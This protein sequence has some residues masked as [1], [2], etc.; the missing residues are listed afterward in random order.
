[1]ALPYSKS[2]E[3][4]QKDQENRQAGLATLKEKEA[5]A[6]LGLSVKTLRQWR[7]KGTGPDYLKLGNGRGA[8]IRYEPEALE[9]FKAQSRIRA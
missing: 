8:A 6:L 1:M 5:A 2:E 4:M 9:Q 7:W 3:T